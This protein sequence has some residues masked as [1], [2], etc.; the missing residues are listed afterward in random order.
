MHSLSPFLIQP[1]S[2]SSSGLAREV[3]GVSVTFLLFGKCFRTFFAG[4]SVEVSFPPFT[5]LL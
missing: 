2:P 3:Q 4:V 5:D 1:S